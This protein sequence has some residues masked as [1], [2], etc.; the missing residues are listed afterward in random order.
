MVTCTLEKNKEPV[1]IA[2][3]EGVAILKQNGREDQK[4]VTFKRDLKE[5]REWAVGPRGREAFRQSA[6]P[7]SSWS[8]SVPHTVQVGRGQ[9][10]GWTEPGRGRGGRAESQSAIRTLI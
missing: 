3:M 6:A 8:R 10:A 5:M 1:G 4:M 7:Q 9:R 2:N